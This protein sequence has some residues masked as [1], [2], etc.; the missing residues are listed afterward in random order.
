MRIL[1]DHCVPKP[2]KYE[3]PGHDVSTAREMGWEALKNGALL[4]KAQSGGFEVFI[5]VDQNIR[6]Q[7]NLKN[8]G[9]AVCVLVGGG[10]TI[11]KLS[12]LVPNLETLLPTIQPGVV[13]EV[14]L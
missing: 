11:E 9:I 6:Y 4:D 14:T 7:Q 5:T 8:R 3:L 10:I 2:F 1:L 13:Y 12:P